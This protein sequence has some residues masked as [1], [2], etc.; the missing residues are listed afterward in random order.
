M[1]FSQRT[2]HE[3]VTD[4]RQALRN[5]EASGLVADSLDVRKALM[6][7]VH[8]GAITLEQAQAELKQIQHS[9]RKSGKL[10]R[11]QAFNRG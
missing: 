10:T 3:A 9:A 6:S 7:R 11:W 5:A 4:K 8:E 2:R 1:D